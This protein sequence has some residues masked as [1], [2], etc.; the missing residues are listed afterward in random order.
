ML[1]IPVYKST[2]VSENG[3][4][5]HCV[6]VTQWATMRSQLEPTAPERQVLS[7]IDMNTPGEK[8]RSWDASWLAE[9]VLHKPVGMVIPSS[10]KQLFR[11]IRLCPIGSH[12]WTFPPQYNIFIIWEFLTIHPD[13]TLFP[14]LPDPP[15]NPYATLQ[16]QITSPVCVTHVLTGIWSNTQWPL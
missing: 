1:S 16:K 3:Y 9:P 14:Y 15:S 5:L 11:C 10:L 7:L 13:H 12:I 2:R 4:K 8:G 6:K